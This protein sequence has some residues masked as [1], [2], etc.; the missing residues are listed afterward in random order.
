MTEALK[1][2]LV[3]IALFAYNQDLYIDQ[4]IESVFAQ[5]YS[6]LEIIL[7]D[8][9]SND[10]TFL[11]MQTAAASYFGPHNVRVNRNSDRLGVA[12]HV[13]KIEEMALGDLIIAAAGDDISYPNRVESIV[14]EWLGTDQSAI[15]LHS[16]YHD[17]DV[18]GHILGT[19]TKSL[20]PTIKKTISGNV[21]TG[22]TEAWSRKLFETF[23]P[24]GLSIT[25]EDRVI[26]T[27]AALLDGIIYIDRPLV[28]Y[29]RGG[30]ST[31]RKDVSKSKAR[32]IEARRFIADLAQ[33][34]CDLESANQKK[35][36]TDDLCNSLIAIA[37]NRLAT[38]HMLTA[39]K[40]RISVLKL[41]FID[42]S[43]VAI[44]I[45]N[46]IYQLIKK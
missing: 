9:H 37:H 35:I 40:S 23:G 36:I 31:R 10:A 28:A 33:V 29:R 26:A 32:S 19:I 38:E 2:P 3:T 18:D 12:G 41:L 13:N 44:R 39:A 15:M 27:R 8:D 43:Y 42:L 45:L 1:R 22:A 6:P 11:K 4:A 7:S 30:I 24:L 25:H 34:I 46:V 16:A 14:D 21:V 20:S 17:M 5:T